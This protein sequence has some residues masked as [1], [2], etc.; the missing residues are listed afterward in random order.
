MKRFLIVQIRPEDEAA[1]NELESF[2]KFGGLSLQDIQRVQADRE[3]IPDLN[4]DDYAGVI[5][6]GG[7]SN[8]SDEYKNQRTQEMERT[9]FHLLDQVVEKD[10]PFLGACYGIGALAAHQGAVVSKEQFGEGVGAVTI[11]LTEAGLK[12]PLLRDLPESFQAFAGHKEACQNLPDSAVLL[13]SSPICPIQMIRVKNNIYATQFHPELDT[14]G[15]V[16]RINVYK[17]AGYFPA[18]EA[19]SLIARV[20]QDTVTQPVRILQNFIERFR[21]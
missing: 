4:L 5:L 2:L 7:P 13:A 14:D 20:R 1:D 19:E 8:I 12:D 3:P 21:V 18:S 10:T 9:I 6:G 11:A 17:H 15:I 16:I